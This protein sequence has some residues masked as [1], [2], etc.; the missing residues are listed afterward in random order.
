MGVDL[1]SPKCGSSLPDCVAPGFAPSLSPE[2]SSP[3]GWPWGA[4][5]PPAPKGYTWQ[6]CKEIKVSVLR[7]D[8]W[9]FTE[10]SKGD[11]GA[12]FVS[13]EDAGTAGRNRTGVGVNL[14]RKIPE[15][16]GMA[17]SEYARQYIATLATKNEAVEQKDFTEGPFRC[18]R[19]EFR[20][21]SDPDGYAH[22]VALAAA[23][24]KTG[25]MYFVMLESPE[26]SWENA[27]KI[28]KPILMMI[29]FDDEM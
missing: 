20:N 14:V 3:P 22:F 13:V 15:R 16:L 7:P 9:H 18:F 19:V 11:T 1:T 27:F 12:C 17:P 10:R 26:K 5:L 21:Q 23:N 4:D 2:S 25:S 29:A 6:A 8:G 28:G 24:D